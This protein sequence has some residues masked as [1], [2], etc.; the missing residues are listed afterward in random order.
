MAQARASK[1]GN[2]WISVHEA[3]SLIGVS[4]AT[5]R[6]WSDAGEIRAFTTPGGHRRFARSAILGLLP[7]AEDERPTLENLGETT[8]RM[9]RVYRRQLVDRCFGLV[10]MRE[11]DESDLR[12]YRELGRRMTGSLFDA[13]D[14]ATP[15]SH[16]EAVEEARLVAVEFGRVS[17]SHRADAPQAVEAFLRFR[18]PFLRELAA[19]A[20]RRGLEI[21]EVTDLLDRA[22]VTMDHLVVS[23]LEGHRR[24]SLPAAGPALN[25]MAMGPE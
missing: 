6:R 11:L 4:P 17:A 9:I 19:A 24:A 22:V 16:V 14:A 2:E 13:I 23:L 7:A 25:A 18:L 21:R 20:R 5:L 8:V 1:S 12:E 10:W 3:C 15:E